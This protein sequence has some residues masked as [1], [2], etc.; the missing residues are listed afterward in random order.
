LTWETGSEG[1]NPSLSAPRSSRSLAFGFT[2]VDGVAVI[3][4][5]GCVVASRTCPSRIGESLTAA[6]EDG[7]NQ[8]LW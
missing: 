5:L 8:V 2:E 4:P 1:S 7:S 6:V 3:Q